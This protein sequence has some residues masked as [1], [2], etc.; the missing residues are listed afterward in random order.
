MTP[1]HPRTLVAWAEAHA[2]RVNKVLVIGLDSAPPA[3]LFDRFA[4]HLPHLARLRAEGAWGPLQSVIPAITIPA[5]A[6]AM[7]GRDPGQLG[8]YGFRRHLHSSYAPGRWVDS[9]D[10]R[11]EAVWD[12]LSRHGRPVIVVGVPPG[13]PPRRV[14]GSFVSCFLTP[15]VHRPATHPRALADT[16]ATIADRYAADV[17]DHRGAEPDR[18]LR[19]VRE[20]T[21]QRFRVFRHLLR[22]G[23]WDFA[24]MVEIGLDRI[25]HAFWGSCDREHPGYV[26]D[27]PYAQTILDYYRLL[28][29]EIG[30]VLQ[31]A[32]D[33]RTA[34][35]IMSDHG[36]K[37]WQG[38]IAI[39]EW[40]RRELYLVL[41]SP[42]GGRGPLQPEMVDWSHTMA[43][44]QGGHCGRVYLNLRGRQPAGVVDPADAERVLSQIEHGLS[45]IAAPDGRAL[46]TR[47][48][49]PETTY[50]ECRGAPPDLIV[51]FGD[52]DWRA[53]G[54]VGANDL[55]VTQNDTGPD[56]AN[57][58]TDGVIIAHVPGAVAE[59]LDGL[60]LVDV[61][62]AVLRILGCG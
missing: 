34:V 27:G 19:D 52:L 62:P 5:W 13:Y 44:G 59:R 20:M 10:V 38:G 16:L 43:W 40:L 26:E 46:L 41:R 50:R 35:F 31:D 39:N 33:A 1:D 61:G 24:M 9:T 29:R 51:Y 18:L 4:S 28:D 11:A 32:V 6:C 7:T 15:D 23:A 45:A 17:A 37:R 12:T 42:P 55:Y 3:L 48:F 53:V 47:V 25:H 54:S 2:G 58:A 49:R 57:H 36:A 56:Q 30:S 22:A 14:R 21:E 60:R 8:I